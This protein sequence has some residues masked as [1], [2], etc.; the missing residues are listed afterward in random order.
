MINRKAQG[1]PLNLIVLAAM[2]ALILVLVVAFTIGGG[3]NFFSK[4]FKTGTT[5]IGD[6]ISVVQAACNNLCEQAKT[7]ATSPAWTSSAYCTK[8]YNIDRDGDGKLGGTKC[9]TDPL[10]LNCGLVGKTTKEKGL[11]CTDIGISCTVD[12]PTTS[13]NY[14][15]CL[16]DSTS[17]KCACITS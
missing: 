7:A 15:T 1:L 3:S 17:N 13:G 10:G 2:A 16:V 5:S 8:K 9:P 14:T 6:E 11:S 4:I 12:L